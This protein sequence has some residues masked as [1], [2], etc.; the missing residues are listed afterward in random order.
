MYRV[1]IHYYKTK[2]I[3]HD[4]DFPLTS[5]INISWYRTYRVLKYLS[6]C[7]ISNEIFCQ[8]YNFL[9]EMQFSYY[10]PQLGK[11]QWLSDIRDYTI[12][13]FRKVVIMFDAWHIYILLKQYMHYHS[14]SYHAEPKFES[15]I[16]FPYDCLALL[17]H[18][19]KDL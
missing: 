8:P 17:K 13:T 11:A 18:D 3:Y 15:F 5:S 6:Y 9:F 7:F 4:N 1:I 2:S 10:L 16:L 14:W 12:Q 19:Q